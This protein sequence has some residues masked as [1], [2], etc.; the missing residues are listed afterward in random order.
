[1][2]TAVITFRRADEN[3]SEESLS[4]I[5][6]HFRNGGV[7]VDSLD[8]L[9]VENEIIFARR[10]EEYTSTV[11][12]IVVLVRDDMEFGWKEIITHVTGEEFITNDNALTLVEN[13]AKARGESCDVEYASIPVASTVIPNKKG[14][15]QGFLLEKDGY[16]LIALPCEEE[17][18][19]D[20]CEGFVAP[21]FNVKYGDKTERVTL[22]YFGRE[23]GLK[24]V[25]MQAETTVC[26]EFTYTCNTR[27]G[28][29]RI[30]LYF[31][32]T[33][34]K[35]KRDQT[36]RFIAEKLNDGIYADYDVTLSERLFDVLQVRKVKLKTAESFTGGRI[37]AEIVKNAGVSEYFTEGIVCYSDRSKVER[38]GV[39]PDDI[40]KEG[41]VSSSVAFQM[42]VGLLRSKNCDVAVATTGLAGPNTDA[43]GKPVGLCYIAVGSRNGVHTHKYILHG[44]R[45]KITETAKNTALFLAIKNI[46]KM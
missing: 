3:F 10:L 22:K 20:M 5:I 38:L 14:L 8:V 42:A 26:G 9:S 13:Y 1:M 23:E 17:Q 12:N 25:L 37:A 33:V 29:T 39:N 35:A 44:D 21:Y 11:D 30:D 43:S 4:A 16:T 34:E 28:D 46:K 2:K 32:E 36:L 27:C 15:V 6:S 7:P 18:F 45:E 41:A 40:N 19:G 24:A 31:P